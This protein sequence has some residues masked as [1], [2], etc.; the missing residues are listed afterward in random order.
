MERYDIE[1]DCSRDGS[2]LVQPIEIA[3]WMVEFADLKRKSYRKKLKNIPPPPK[4]RK[5]T[6]K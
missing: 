4:P 2:I 1:N 6:L 3:K 5:F